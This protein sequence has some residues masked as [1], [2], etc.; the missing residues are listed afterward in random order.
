MVE[1]IDGSTVREILVRE[2]GRVKA[3]D[4]LVRFDDK[5]LRSEEAILQAQAAEL[6][7]RRNRLEA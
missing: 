4:V 3:G 1:H 2:G 6:A 7:A 5:L